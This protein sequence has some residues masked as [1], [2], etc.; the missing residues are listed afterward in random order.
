MA[1]S[2]HLSPVRQGEGIT[3]R[4]PVL[5]HERQV[6]RRP[7]DPLA[8]CRIMNCFD[9]LEELIFNAAGFASERQKRAVEAEDL[10]EQT[11]RSPTLGN[12][13]LVEYPTVRLRASHSGMSVLC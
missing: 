9:W 12:R 11:H 8:W 7:C 10:V 6:G 5:P 2:E 1:Q 4:P 3:R 13:C